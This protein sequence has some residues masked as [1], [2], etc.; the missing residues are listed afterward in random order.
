MS[1]SGGLIWMRSPDSGNLLRS[2][3][4]QPLR[5]RRQLRWCD[6]VQANPGQFTL[7]FFEQRTHGVLLRDE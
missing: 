5:I 7:E 2:D 6:A 1:A 4:A 3:L